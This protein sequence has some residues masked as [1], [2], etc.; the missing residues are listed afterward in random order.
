[1]SVGK[2]NPAEAFAV[3]SASGTAISVSVEDASAVS[4]FIPPESLPNS[5]QIS[6]EEAMD[7]GFRLSE[8]RMVMGFWRARAGLPPDAVA[9]RLSALRHP[10]PL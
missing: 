6:W 10:A 7:T 9:R 2:D 8:E 4:I 3:L 1:M 5:R